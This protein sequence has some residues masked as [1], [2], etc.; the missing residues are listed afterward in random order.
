MGFHVFNDAIIVFHP[1]AIMRLID[2]ATKNLHSKRVGG[3]RRGLA[4]GEERGER[5]EGREPCIIRNL[6]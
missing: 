6:Y 2:L 5:R 3:G 4:A 1:Y